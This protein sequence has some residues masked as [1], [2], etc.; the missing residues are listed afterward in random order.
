MRLNTIILAV[1]TL[2]LSC[3]D[4]RKK[5][6]KSEVLDS[7]SVKT[8]SLQPIKLNWQ[9][10]KDTTI[11]NIKLSFVL[12]DKIKFDSL[13][14]LSI[15]AEIPYEDFGHLLLPLEKCKIIKLENGISDSLC[16]SHN[17]DDHSFKIYTIKGLWK[18]KNKLM[19]TKKKKGIP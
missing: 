13:Q 7:S 19:A 15:T 11:N 10:L 16:D 9:E 2:F 8:K 1:L 17:D 14:H 4:S 18:A 12:L 3:S 5:E 6:N